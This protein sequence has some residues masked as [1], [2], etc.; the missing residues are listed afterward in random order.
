[1]GSIAIRLPIDE[2]QQ[3]SHVLYSPGI[4]IFLLLVGFLTNRGFRL[5]FSR[6]QCKIKSCSG[7]I[8]AT[9]EKNRR[10]GLYKLRG[11]T[12]S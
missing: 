11:E 5:E 1:M 8:I 2:I 9:A 4:R 7:H 10:N 6:D 12:L 3:I